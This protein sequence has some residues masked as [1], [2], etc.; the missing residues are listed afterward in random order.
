MDTQVRE[1]NDL[2]N[3]LKNSET[4]FKQDQTALT[5]E[6]DE[7]SKHITKLEHKEIQY[8]HEIKNRE[9]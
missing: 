9:L 8:K 7:L 5:K 3:Q 1:I 2:K 4:K 6:R